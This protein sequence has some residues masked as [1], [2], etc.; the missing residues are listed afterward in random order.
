MCSDVGK[1]AARAA[2]RGCCTG[3]TR[4][5]NGGRCGA[6]NEDEPAFPTESQL[7][8]TT[9]DDLFQFKTWGI[10]D[11]SNIKNNTDY[12]CE[13]TRQNALAAITNLGHMIPFYCLNPL[14]F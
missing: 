8:D 3:D 2:G 7:A 12:F 11:K 1:Q 9:P 10:G 5:G 6:G 13:D 4:R 14:I